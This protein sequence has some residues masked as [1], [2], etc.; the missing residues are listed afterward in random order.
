V[1]AIGIVPADIGDALSALG[2]RRGDVV[3]LHSDAVVAAQLPSMPE[4]QRLDRVIEALE[5][6]MGADGTLVMPT[7]SYSFT[8]NETF[9]AL[10]TPSTVGMLTERFRTRVGVRRTADPI[11]SIAANG[12]MAQELASLPVHECFGP[13]SAFALLHRVNALVVCLGCSLTNGGTFVHYVERSHGV[14][15][16]Y[17][18]TFYGVI[19]W[20]DG[21]STNNSV[22]YYVR[23]LARKSGADL[24][25]LRRR[26]EA[27]GL[28]RSAPVGRFQMLGVRTADWFSTAWS[29]LDEDPVSLIEEGTVRAADKTLSA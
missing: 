19:K 18:K 17:D 21:T 1:S 4:S 20:P 7:F 15:Y 23:D 3:L 26:L 6:V 13:Q 24:R 22:V 14:N 16:R 12:P 2:L 9:D 28:L 29:M 11:F 25:R 27:R 5:R 8:K 10:Q